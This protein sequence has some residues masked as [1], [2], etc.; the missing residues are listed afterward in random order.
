MPSAT[1]NFDHLKPVGFL[2]A[3][4][5]LHW[6]RHQD[7]DMQWKIAR[8]VKFNFEKALRDLVREVP[9]LNGKDEQELLFAADRI[10]NAFWDAKAKAIANQK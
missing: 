5:A 2:P 1:Q 9:A 10:V 6:N 8:T 7:E 3:L 4:H